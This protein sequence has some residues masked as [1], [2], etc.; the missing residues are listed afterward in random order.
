M[1]IDYLSLEDFVVVVYKRVFLVSK[2]VVFIG[3]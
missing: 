3:S 1:K 2:V